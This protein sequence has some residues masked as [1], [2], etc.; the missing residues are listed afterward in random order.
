MSS[1]FT[2][3]LTR[4]IPGHILWEDS[5]CFAF[6]D[7]RPINR[8][9]TLVVPIQEIDMW[10]DLSAETASHCMRVAQ[11][12]GKA[13]MKAYKPNR[14]GLMIAGFEVSHVHL[15]VIPIDDMSHLDFANANSDISSDELTEDLELL[16]RCLTEAGHTNN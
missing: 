2:R 5:E 6:L 13:Q 16:T 15:H 1:I 7:I 4:E 8:G 11:T 12:I 10:T 9:H 14:V 3:I